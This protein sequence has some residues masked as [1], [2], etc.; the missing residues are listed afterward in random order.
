MDQGEKK[1]TFHAVTGNTKQAT[2]KSTAPCFELNKYM[3]HNTQTS[4]AS[5]KKS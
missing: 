2:N 1:E 3:R 5:E 4:T